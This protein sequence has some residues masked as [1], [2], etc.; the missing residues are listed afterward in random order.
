[1]P[2]GHNQTSAPKMIPNIS[3]AY[4]QTVQYVSHPQKND[5]SGQIQ[6]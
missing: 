3:E 1:M 4:P 2:F 5:E 6:A